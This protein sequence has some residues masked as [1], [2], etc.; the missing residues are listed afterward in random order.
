[1]PLP[2]YML[3]QP[4]SSPIDILSRRLAERGAAVSLKRY[5]ST[6]QMRDLDCDSVDEASSALRL[7][8]QHADAHCLVVDAH[9]P[10][11]L[12]HLNRAYVDN[13]FLVGYDSSEEDEL[14]QHHVMRRK[15]R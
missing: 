9:V 13:G 10:T 8:A 15:P 4:V 6:L 14:G 1:M 2:A 11:I 3:Q 5:G 12:S 7:I